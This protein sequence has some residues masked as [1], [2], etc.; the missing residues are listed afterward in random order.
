MAVVRM[1]DRLDGSGVEMGEF[2]QT[3][4]LVF[5]LQKMEHQ[6]WISW[7]FALVYSAISLLEFQHGTASHVVLVW[8][9][10]TLFTFHG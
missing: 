6:I 5:S 2:V 1:F 10:W 8:L 4:Q 3:E 7:H 9:V